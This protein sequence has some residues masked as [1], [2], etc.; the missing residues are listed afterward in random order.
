MPRWRALALFA[1]LALLFLV[2]NR[3]AYQ[4]W[5]SD[6]ELDNLAWT[7]HARATNFITGTVSP[8][9][10]KENFRPTGHFYFYLM[11]RLAGLRFPWYVAVIHGLHFATVILIWLVLRRL[12]LDWLGAAAGVLFF[13]FHMAVFDA[14]WKPMYVFDVLC[15]ALSAAALLAWMNRRWVFS[16]VCFWLA[17][18]SKEIAVAL[19]AVLAFYE[20]WLG[21]RRWKPLLPFFAVSLS[22][23]LQALFLNPNVNN[24]YTLRF[25]PAA[26]WKSLSF[27]SSKMLLIPYAGLALAA[28]LL[29]KD[30]LVRFGLI[31]TAI[32]LAPM[33]FV[34]GRL[35]GA[36]LYT[37]L[38][39]LA[40][41]AGA[42]AARAPIWSVAVAFIVWLPF[43]Y[44]HLREN[45]RAALTVA[46]ENRAYYRELES[47]ARG[48]PDVRAFIYDGAPQG[49]RRWGILGALKL[50]YDSVDVELYSIEDNYAATPSLALLSWDPATRTLA[51]ASR[52]EKAPESSYI[53]MSPTTPI[54]QLEKGW[55]SR[56]DRFRWTRPYAVARL[57]RPA[58]A[59]EF[60]LQANISPGYLSSVGLV[61]VQVLLDGVSLE[62]REFRKPG[63][64]TVR[65]PLHG[66]FTGPV[67][68][69]FKVKPEFRPPNDPRVLGLPVGGF[70]F[71][72]KEVK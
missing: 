72:S 22:F 36:Y 24:E 71:V 57:Y 51:T 52:T 42:I 20:V 63:W 66:T 7:K 30:R 65:W 25:T 49:L 6:D 3:G 14:Y 56:Q 68:V 28:L 48:L 27:Y 44:Q 21:E 41:T 39:G 61:D 35:Y 43:N 53:T 33:L 4:G 59:A 5:F 55:Y 15:G 16:F 26:F 45:R 67:R 47:A 58:G 60:E 12:G 50:V 8:L 1:V 11:S 37:P 62:H 31:L 10:Q 69:E 18:K 23:G 32:L 46:Q 9:F 2:A 54:W 19:P 13:A 70:G 34:P 29:M 40:I 64:Q 17:Y 38:L